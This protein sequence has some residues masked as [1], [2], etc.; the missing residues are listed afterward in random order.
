MNKF[1][2]TLAFAGVAAAGTIGT[3]NESKAEAP[4]Q[5]FDGVKKK[6]SYAV[7]QPQFAFFGIADGVVENVDSM[8]VKNSAVRVLGNDDFVSD[9]HSGERAIKV[10]DKSL[11]LRFGVLPAQTDGFYT[12]SFWT[13][14][15]SVSGEN[16]FSI[17][18]DNMDSK[19]VRQY[20]ANGAVSL[21][22]G[23]WV[24]YTYN[25]T[26]T[27]FENG[28]YI[29]S[30]TSLTISAYGDFLIDDIT[31]KD[32]NGLN[33]ICDGDFEP[34]ELLGWK[35]GSMGVGAAKQ[36]DGSVVFGVSS[37]DI[38]TMEKMGEGYFQIK[39]KAN[40][41]AGAVAA[42]DFLGKQ[43]QVMNR[44]GYDWGDAASN[45]NVTGWTKYS[46]TL[47]GA[48]STGPEIYFGGNPFQALCYFK[49]MSV[50]DVAGNE[51]LPSPLTK[52]GYAEGLAESLLEDVICDN[53]VTAPSESTWGNIRYCFE[54]MPAGAQAYIKSLTPKEDGTVAERGLYKYSYI[55]SKYG[56][57]YYDYLGYKGTPK[58]LA[59]P[60]M[61]AETE[62]SAIYASVG[63]AFAGLAIALFFAVT[64][65][66]KKASLR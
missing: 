45:T 46:Y 30:R 29:D 25:F 60:R 7:T 21:K 3:L 48:V 59:S 36:D 42:F 15:L 40:A 33:Y 54:H 53:G 18:F 51:L 10:S 24:Q 16:R 22:V 35:F 47:K 31:L 13:K 39:P 61:M 5:D 64:N 62:K 6:V 58:A 8:G 2:A 11:G 9:A 56:S 14:Q 49:N 52:E 43:A 19:N 41:D 63:V 57:K 32:A 65:K 44:N 26:S 66:K 55:I 38:K 28:S 4:K 17:R 37:W 12:F 50:K 34:V 1:L 20:Y 23:E 27:L